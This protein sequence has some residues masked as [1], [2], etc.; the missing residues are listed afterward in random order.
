MSLKDMAADFLEEYPNK[1]VSLK[2]YRYKICSMLWKM[3]FHGKVQLT[4]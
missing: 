2:Y 3:S 1:D 4:W